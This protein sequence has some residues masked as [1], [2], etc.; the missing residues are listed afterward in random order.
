MLEEDNSEI[1]PII[2]I[3]LFIFVLFLIMYISNKTGYY[4]YKKHTK[5]V[6]TNESIKQFEKDISE[7]KDV[8][9]KEYVVDDYV[10]YSNFITKTGSTIGDVVESFMN[11]GI[12]KTLK[13][14]S[15]LFYE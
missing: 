1:N 5:S 13:L 10:D 2:K 4:E 3:L 8:S 9:L 11:D 6:L 7:G 15:A 14:L 12:K